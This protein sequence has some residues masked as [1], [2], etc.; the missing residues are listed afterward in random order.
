MNLK[1]EEIITFLPNFISFEYTLPNNS[2]D[3]VAGGRPKRN[4]TSNHA[5]SRERAARGLRKL[6]KERKVECDIPKAMIIGAFKVIAVT[7]DARRK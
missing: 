5:T 2:F 1:S 3:Y 7:V 6:D 4:R